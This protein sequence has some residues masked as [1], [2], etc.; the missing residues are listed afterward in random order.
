MVARKLGV[1]ALVVV[2]AACWEAKELVSADRPV[3][4]DKKKTQG[5]LCWKRRKEAN[6]KNKTKT[7]T[8]P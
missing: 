1:A 2:V 8:S 5:S 3:C 6:N 7:N 4:V